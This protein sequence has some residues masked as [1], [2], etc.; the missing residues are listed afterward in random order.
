MK[1][2]NLQGDNIVHYVNKL[3]EGHRYNLNGEILEF[4]ERFLIADTLA[5]LSVCIETVK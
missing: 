4:I 2:L 5:L 3:L 1:K